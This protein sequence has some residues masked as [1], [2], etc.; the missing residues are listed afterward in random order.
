M[1]RALFTSEGLKELDLTD[2]FVVP[3]TGTYLVASISEIPFN[4]G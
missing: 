4:G 1:T 3:K 2:H